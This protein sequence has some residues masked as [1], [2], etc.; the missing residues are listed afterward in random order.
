[1]TQLTRS[2]QRSAPPR[3]EFIDE[4]HE[5]AD[6]DLFDRLEAWAERRRRRQMWW[7]WTLR[8]GRGALLVMALGLVSGAV[9]LVT[10]A[11]AD[12]WAR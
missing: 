2:Y 7:R 8:L 9:W 10:P 11:G 5:R 6:R 3:A 12:W 1:M 4:V